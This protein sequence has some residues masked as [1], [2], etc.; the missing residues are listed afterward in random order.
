MSGTA[1]AV[2]VSLLEPGGGT[3]NLP[4]VPLPWTLSLEGAVDYASP[5]LVSLS[6]SWI[7]G[8]AGESVTAAIYYTVSVKKRLIA[9]TVTAPA[10]MLEKVEVFYFLP[11]D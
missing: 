9:S 8:A 3:Q 2:D 10:S 6:A 5:D 1:A 11:P 7:A 4:A